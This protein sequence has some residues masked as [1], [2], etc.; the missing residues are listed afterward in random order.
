M[1]ELTLD[2]LSSNIEKLKFAEERVINFDNKLEL[3]IDY[4]NQIFSNLSIVERL[5]KLFELDLGKSIVSTSGGAQSVIL[6]S[7]L[8]ALK[9]N[10]SNAINR[11]LEELQ[12][13]FI[14]TGDNFV[15]TIDYLIQLKKHFGLN[16]KRYSHSLKADEFA[17]NINLLRESGFSEI[18]AF[19]QLTKVR[20]MQAIISK[21]DAKVWIAGNRRDQSKSRNQLD[22][23]QFQNGLIKIFPLAD[24]SSFEVGRIIEQR[25]LPAHPL[26]NKFR[27][28]GNRSET[29]ASDGQYEKSGRHAGVKEECGL[30]RFWTKL[31]KVVISPNASPQILDLI[32]IAELPLL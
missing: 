31:G 30:H 16:I 20:S 1:R 25:S 32:P 28:I 4:L 6:L 24:I 23:A 9:G 5:E 15:E 14:D 29:Q 21:L 26:A 19:D 27:S 7:H 12:I 11:K 3:R 10:S 17:Y 8:A 13:I 18:D 22:F 2:E